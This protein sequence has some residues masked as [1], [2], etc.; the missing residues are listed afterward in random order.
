MQPVRQFVDF[1]HVPP[2]QAEIDARLV[3]WA[4]WSM[5]R[6]DRGALPKTSPGFQLYR[7]TGLWDGRTA[8]PDAV[9]GIDAQR[10]QKGVSALPGPHRLAISW[11]YIKRSNPRRAAS[12]LGQTMDG[13]RRL[14]LD[15]RTM[16]INR[17]V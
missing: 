11:C 17:Q 6:H 3:N 8:I 2:H 16:L 13:L 1:N 5:S 4:R 15:G 10:L 14:I 7:S 9:D 12:D